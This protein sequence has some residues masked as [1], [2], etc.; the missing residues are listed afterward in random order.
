MKS[1]LLHPEL[2]YMAYSHTLN[3]WSQ[4]K[5][6]TK[7]LA[8]G[9]QVLRSVPLSYH[10]Q[11]VTAAEARTVSQ[12]ESENRWTGSRPPKEGRE[13]TGGLY[14]SMH[15]QALRGELLHYGVLDLSAA[16]RGR[17]QNTDKGPGGARLHPSLGQVDSVDEWNISATRRIFLFKTIQ[18]VE[19]ADFSKASGNGRQFVH[20]LGQKDEILKALEKA[21]YG[22][23]EEAYAASA[24]H[25]FDRGLG[26]AIYDGQRQKGGLGGM[27]ASTVRDAEVP[28]LYMG[29]NLVLFNVAGIPEGKLRACQ[30]FV[31][32]QDSATTYFYDGLERIIDKS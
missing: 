28:Q 26:N 30:E 7:R 24:D 12:L 16:K 13:G 17:H 23:V 5:V 1:R 25:S 20:D 27:L 9:T 10:K 4:A 2:Y 15:F 29:D 22:T 3:A 11:M 14:L 6:P 19:I 21:G 18:P 8:V 31:F 32:Y